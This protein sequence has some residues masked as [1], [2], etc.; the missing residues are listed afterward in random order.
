MGIEI[1]FVDASDLSKLKNAIK[2]NTKVC[3]AIL[4]IKNV[5]IWMH[6]RYLYT[7]KTH[8]SL[9]QIFSKR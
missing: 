4:E 3:F 9:F 8:T 6:F 5:H 2:P 1:S 7:S